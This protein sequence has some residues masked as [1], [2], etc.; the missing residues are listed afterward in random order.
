MCDKG[1][2]KLGEVVRV[3][4]TYMCENAKELIS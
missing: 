4:I 2:E 1:G 3:C